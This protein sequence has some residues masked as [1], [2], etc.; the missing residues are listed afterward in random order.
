MDPNAGK[1]DMFN[2]L[3]KEQCM[4]LLEKETFKRVTVSFYKYILLDNL[5]ELRD[6]LYNKWNDLGVLG[7]IYLAD[8]GI[9]AQLSVPEHN[10]RDF[11]QN[12]NSFSFFKDIPFKIAVEDDGKSF[13]KLTIKIRK[14]IVTDGLSI[15]DYDVTNVGEHLS[16]KQWN[17]A[18]N[19]G[20]TVVDMRNHYES[21]IG[22]FKGAICPD[23]ETFKE[24]LPVVKDL[25][26]GKE[27]E[28]VLLYCTGGIRC[29]KTSAYLK[30]H[31]FENVSQLHGG[32]IDYVRQLNKDESLE[33]KFEGKNFVFDERR[34]ERISDDI[35]S[36]CHQCD[37]ACDTHVN[38][39]NE[40]CNLL[41]LQCD[42]CQEKHE[43][44]CSVEC[45]EVAN[46][47]EE[48]RLKLRK[49]V[50]NK[51]MYYSHSKVNLN[52]KGLK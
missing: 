17:D 48:Q 34:G 26:K 13:F 44:C 11:I 6:D 52:L 5:L 10:W 2:K 27:K 42:S 37:E 3:S 9:N 47:P 24:E 25:L 36:N 15:E 43:N 50:E 28:E 49:G 31:G 16:A 7:R 14:Q 45:I 8:E 33:N 23:V 39:K 4:A 35:I 29:E 38:C 30:H 40:N 1:K 22:K 46:L 19:K 41:F 21:E 12:V 32:I 20:A 18:I 51:K